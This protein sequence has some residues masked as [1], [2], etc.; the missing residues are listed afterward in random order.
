MTSMIQWVET[1]SPFRW[2]VEDLEAYYGVLWP[3]GG[4]FCCFSILLLILFAFR[5]RHLNT[6]R[7]LATYPQA[8]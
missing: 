3:G 5:D 2:L 4:V 1:V 8:G 6:R 7:I